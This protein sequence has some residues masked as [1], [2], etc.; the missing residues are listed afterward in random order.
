MKLKI[1]TGDLNHLLRTVS[2][3]VEKHEIK[4]YLELG[5]TMLDWIKTKD[6]ACGLAAPQV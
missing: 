6:N 2:T 3:P 5:K 1:E 4:Q